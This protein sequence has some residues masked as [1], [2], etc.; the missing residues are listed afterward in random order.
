MLPIDSKEAK[1]AAAAAAR[2]NRLLRHQ[3]EQRTKQAPVNLARLGAEQDTSGLV[4]VGAKGTR[5]FFQQRK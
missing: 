2:Q 4:H 1:R 3:S 5:K